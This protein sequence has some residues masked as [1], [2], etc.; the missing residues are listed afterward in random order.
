MKAV[1]WGLPS[2]RAERAGA[3]AAV[4]GRG[5]IAQSPG[6]PIEILTLPEGLHFERDLVQFTAGHNDGPGESEIGRAQGNVRPTPPS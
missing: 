2:D 1:A 6:F 3:F 5:E 4:G